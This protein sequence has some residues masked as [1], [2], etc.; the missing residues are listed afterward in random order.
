MHPQSP[1]GGG[2]RRRSLIN[3]A[4][5]T[6]PLL[7]ASAT[8]PA[9]AASPPSGINS[10]VFDRNSFTIEGGH[11]VTLSGTITAN[12]T[13]T[14]PTSFA[15][16][17]LKS[18]AGEVARS[19]TVNVTPTGTKQGRFTIDINYDLPGDYLVRSSIPG[20]P[21]ATAAITVTIVAPVG[22]TT[23]AWNYRGAMTTTGILPDTVVAMPGAG[24]DALSLPPTN[25]YAPPNPYAWNYGYEQDERLPYFAWAH[26]SVS[27]SPRMTATVTR[28]QGMAMPASAVLRQYADNAGRY[29]G[30]INLPYRGAPTYLYDYA[31]P[32]P[33]G[34]VA[35]LSRIS[36]IREWTLPVT[37][38][39][40]GNTATITLPTWATFGV[41]GPHSVSL[42][43]PGYPDLLA[44]LWILP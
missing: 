40:D 42:H 35:D 15:L 5:W 10:V 9:L 18:G 34:A 13:T 23:I 11:T 24:R 21:D 2:V 8:T 20:Y 19:Y 22:G 26:S 37:P 36:A 27:S 4:A 1:P 7:L 25:P 30:M 3:A 38:N 44:D 33:R 31:S 28:Q 39:G 43:T 12:N 41:G 17:S 14:L 16:L 32:A 6:T 29:L